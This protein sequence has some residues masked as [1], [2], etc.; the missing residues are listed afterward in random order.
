MFLTA[1]DKIACYNLLCANTYPRCRGG[2]ERIMSENEKLQDEREVLIQL[3]QAL[4]PGQIREVIARAK[5]LL[6]LR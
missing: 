2:K 1:Y 6:P 4:T 5:E 3:I